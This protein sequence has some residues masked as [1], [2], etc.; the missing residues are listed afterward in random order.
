MKLDWIVSTWTLRKN[1]KIL[2][3]LEL[4]ILYIYV[5]LM[6]LSDVPKASCWYFSFFTFQCT[7]MCTVQGTVQYIEY[8]PVV[9]ILYSPVYISVYIGY[10]PVYIPVYIVYIQ[11][12][13]MYGTVHPNVYCIQS[14][15]HPSV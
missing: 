11:V 3:S 15:V 10:S 14:N 4:S 2:R 6:C 7:F 9:Y 12:Y 5:Q 1:Q 13:I 8:I